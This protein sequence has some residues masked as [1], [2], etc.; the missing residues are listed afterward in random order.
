MV[1][2]PSVPDTG[3]RRSDLRGS[4][5]ATPGLTALDEQREASMADEGG[6]SGAVMESEDPSPIPPVLNKDHGR[7]RSHVFVI[8]IAA[9]IV[10]AT[11]MLARRPQ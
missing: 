6:S 5:R 9:G 1:G 8:G 4:A 2:K 7:G 10:A 11:W 3:D